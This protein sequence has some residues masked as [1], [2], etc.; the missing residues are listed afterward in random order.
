MPFTDEQ[1]FLEAIFA[2]YHDDGLRFI[3]ADFLDDAGDPDRAELVRVQVALGRMNEDDPLRAELSEKQAELLAANQERWTEHLGDLVCNCEF[4]RGVLDSVVID[5]A[6]F[7]SRGAELLRR[8]SLRRIRLRDS[9]EVFPDL[10]ASPL[11]EKIPEL[12]FCGNSLGNGG[13]NLLARSDFLKELEVLD[14]GFNGIDDLGVKTLARAINLPKLTTLS[15]SFNGRITS[16]GIAELASSPF[17]AGLMSLDLTNNEIDDGGVA[18]LVSSKSLLQLQNVRLS[19]NPV[20]DAGVAAFADS[21]L[22]GRQL[23]RTG[24][25]ELRTNQIGSSG[26]KILAECPKLSRCTA[27]DLTGNTIGDSG[28]S[29]IVR[30]ANLTNLK[31]LKVG[32]NQITDTGINSLRS[33]WPRIL[34]QLKI[35]DLSGNRLTSWSCRFLEGITVNSQVILDVSRNLQSSVVTE[36][37][38]SSSEGM[39]GALQSVADAA[40][41]AELRRRVSNPSMRGCERP[42]S[43]G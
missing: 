28:L 37:P 25:L 38:G 20:G 27:L 41:A 22:L 19:E 9:A 32:Q 6:Q 3:Y 34:S 13:V 39:A 7:L 2:R 11:V 24:R 21:D 18:A 5:A 29:A 33:Q 1:P 31:V 35:L 26:A 16:S 8:V 42:N 23:S 17:L 43:S 30:S 10:M 4:R 36:H 14:L 12:D 15:L 40:E